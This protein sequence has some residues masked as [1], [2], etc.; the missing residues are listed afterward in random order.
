[1]TTIND[2]HLTTYNLTY[3]DLQP[4]TQQEELIREDYRA[5]VGQRHNKPLM[6]K[7]RDVILSAVSNHNSHLEKLCGRCSYDND[8]P[9]EPIMNMLEI[10]EQIITPLFHIV[11]SMC[12][13]CGYI[14][15]VSVVGMSCRSLYI[16]NYCLTYKY[17]CLSYCYSQQAHQN[18][19]MKLYKRD[20][21]NYTE[22]LVDQHR[23]LGVRAISPAY[24]VNCL[25]CHY[26]ADR[27]YFVTFNFKCDESEFSNEELTEIKQTI[28][29]MVKTNIA[30]KQTPIIGWF[31]ESCKYSMNSFD[32]IRQLFCSQFVKDMLICDGKY[33]LVNLDYHDFAFR[34]EMF[35]CEIVHNV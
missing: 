19:V 14:R 4:L 17:K 31:M 35:N 16:K 32:L 6:D 9:L 2:F 12:K 24:S 26:R 34:D 27:M 1:M 33:K 3:S 13:K 29:E 21:D 8:A 7:M 15:S 18:T 25:D 11:G 28:N 20:N 5:F 10:P 22:Y 23:R 30:D